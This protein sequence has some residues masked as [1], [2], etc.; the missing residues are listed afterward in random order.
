MDIT[1]FENKRWH[2][3]DQ[4]VEFRH[5]AA[6]ELIELGAALDIGC[7]DGLL[8]ELLKK[9]GIPAEGV[10]IS[11]E[12]VNKCRAKN[13][14]ARVHAFNEPLPFKDEAFEYAVLLDV[15][16]HV[17]DPAT[18]L[19]EAARVAKKVIVGVPNFSSLPARVQ[20]LVGKVP[21]NNTPHKGHLYWFNRHALRH[22]AK[23]AGL[24]VVRE[25]DN[26]FFPLSR[27]GSVWVRLWPSLFALSFVVV[28]EKN[29]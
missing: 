3:H 19:A 12:A 2:V 21:E 7:G 13:L 28:L 1:E 26:T 15:L 27:M 22:V 11:A 9:K 23:E 5:K 10:D 24:H 29:D 4:K 20:V 8:L 18:L 25:K 14:V 6:A 16:E 17:Y